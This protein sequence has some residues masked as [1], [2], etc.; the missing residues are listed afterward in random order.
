MYHTTDV[1]IKLEI[2][3]GDH[4]SRNMLCAY[5]QITVCLSVEMVGI[6]PSNKF[7]ELVL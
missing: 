4:C 6:L 3:R 1:L 5:V 7:T 2:R